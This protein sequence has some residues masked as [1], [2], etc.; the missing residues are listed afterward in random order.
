MAKASECTEICSACNRVLIVNNTG[1]PA[2][3]L[4]PD[5]HWFPKARRYTVM[6]KKIY[7]K[8]ASAL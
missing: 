2:T 7:Y 5:P 4:T 8:H 6:V 1:C 3:D